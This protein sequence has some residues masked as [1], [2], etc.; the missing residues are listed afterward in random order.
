MLKRFKNQLAHLSGCTD[1]N[2]YKQNSNK[3]RLKLYLLAVVFLILA[4]V[5]LVFTIV[6]IKKAIDVYNDYDGLMLKEGETFEY[7]GNIL[8]PV[9][10]FIPSVLLAFVGIRLLLMAIKIPKTMEEIKTSDSAV[11]QDE[12]LHHK[13]IKCR[14]CEHPN[15]S[16]SEYCEKCGTKLD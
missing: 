8:S 3:L 4:V 9:L 6:L 12:Y 2:E 1:N 15:D 10:L 7:V 14:K 11:K 13:K 5:G 16:H